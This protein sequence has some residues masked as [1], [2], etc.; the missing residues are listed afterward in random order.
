VRYVLPLDKRARLLAVGGKAFNLSLL[1]EA[2]LRVPR[3]F[4]LTTRAFGEALGEKWEQF[5]A[6]GPGDDVQALL[7]RL[8]EKAM[9]VVF[10]ASLEAEI[11][12]A[13]A[14]LDA[15][16]VAVRSSMEIEDGEGASFAGQFESVLGVKAGGLESAVRRCWASAFNGRAHLYRKGVWPR[17]G[18]IV[19]E[20][21]EPEVSGVAF[22]CH[23]VTGDRRTVVVEAVYGLCEPLVSG[24][25]TPDRYCV[26]REGLEER[27]VHVAP[28]QEYLGIDPTG[29]G[30]VLIP[31]PEELRLRRKLSGEML[32]QIVMT[33]GRVES[34]LGTP[35]DVEW[36]Q[37]GGELYL[38]QARPVTG[39][40]VCQG[41]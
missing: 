24:S 16:S 8:R 19:Q 9:G 11:R 41:I 34:L 20:M 22:S 12:E 10:P 4:V 1:A 39:L 32:A 23:P 37:R 27:E 38:L 18:V 15:P 40:G 25:V 30:T 31:V 28:Q 26:D 2:G 21:V 14:S 29:D 36:V 6:I 3:G 13:F 7:P 17:M 33:T 5:E 35:V